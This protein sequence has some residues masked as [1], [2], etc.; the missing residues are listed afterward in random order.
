MA[1][2]SPGRMTKSLFE[3]L[4]NN[5]STSFL[6]WLLRRVR[7]TVTARGL[8]EAAMPVAAST[9]RRMPVRVFFR[10][11][12]LSAV[13]AST[14]WRIPVRVFYRRSSL[15][16][17]APSTYWRNPGTDFNKNKITESDQEKL[18]ADWGIDKSKPLILLPGRLTS[19]K[20]Q[21]VFIEALKLVNE[22]INKKH[23]RVRIFIEYIL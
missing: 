9:A 13:A 10:H 21:E 2:G 6:L 4:C 19:W 5:T 14:A 23:I 11:A 17:L 12:T 22:K 20:G 15:S 18:I 1:I 7:P 3:W 8:A 16:T